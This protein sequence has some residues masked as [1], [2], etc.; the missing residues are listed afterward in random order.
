MKTIIKLLSLLLVVTFIGCKDFLDIND[1]PNSPTDP[2]PAKLLSGSQRYMVLPLCQ[3]NFLGTGLSSYVHYLSSRESE[4]YGMDG[5]ANNPYN[6]WNYFYLYCTPDFDAIINSTE[7]AGN[8]I[9]S[10]IAKTL[11]AYTFS[12]MVD[13]WGDIPYK[14]FNIPGLIHPKADPS[15]EIYNELIKILESGSADLQDDQAPNALTPGSADFFYGGNRDKWIQLNNTVKLKLLLQSRKAKSDITDWQNKLNALVSANNFMAAGNDFEFW[16]TSKVS[17]NE[18]HPF[19]TS[20]Y[21]T[22]SGT[23]TISPYIYE[24]MKGY[25]QYNIANN[26]LAGVSDPRI[27]YYF[28]NQLTA[29]GNSQN[30]HEYRDGGFLSII[31]VGNSNQHAS[32]QANSLSKAGIYLCGG[33]YDAG[34]G[35][36]VNANAGNGAAPHK[37]ITYAAYKFMMAELALVGDISGNAKTLLKEALEA[38]IDHVNKVVTKGGQSGIPAIATSAKDDFVNAVLANYDAA[39]SNDRKLEIIMTEKWVH[40]FFNSIDAYTDYRRTG[41]P[42]LFNVSNTSDPGYAVNPTPTAQSPARIPVT[43]YNSYPRSLY[44]PTTSE[45]DRNPNITQKTDVTTKFI[46]WDK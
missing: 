17:P 46:F 21:A 9:Y 16:F 28:Y 32:D 39:S 14:E 22:S 5:A 2:D 34:T 10:G 27:P 26:P 38:S 7:P 23:N 29:A 13:V 40:N 43:P 42:A 15:A 19:F 18:R 37:M 11:K 24:I 44:Y 4:N 3:G 33:K 30:P 6:S 12:M 25:N 45:V 36:T 31:Y 20:T 35:G 41:Y 1:S 8:K